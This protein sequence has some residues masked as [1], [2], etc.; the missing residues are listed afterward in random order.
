MAASTTPRGGRK[1]NYLKGYNNE[2][3][4][5]GR[6]RR[7]GYYVLRS[8]GSHG[9]FDIVALRPDPD[10]DVLLIQVKTNRQP[11]PAERRALEAFGDARCSWRKQLWVYHDGKRNPTIV[12]IPYV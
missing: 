5:I 9:L 7:R 4:T 3:R 11:G 8:S 6:L 10:Q 1:T 2:L 12:E